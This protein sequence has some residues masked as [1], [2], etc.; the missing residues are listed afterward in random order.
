[1][2][3][4][5]CCIDAETL[6]DGYHVGLFYLGLMTETKEAFYM[7]VVGNLIKFLAV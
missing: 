6:S 2:T 5:S 4:V 7:K 1:M 3:S